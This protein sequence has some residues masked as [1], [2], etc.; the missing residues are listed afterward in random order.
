MGGCMCQLCFTNYF[1]FFL[2]DCLG[3]ESSAYW[4][5]CD[6]AEVMRCLE[7]VVCGRSVH[8]VLFIIPPR[9][10]VAGSIIFYC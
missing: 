6:Y 5:L 8:L 9:T 3:E 4:L 1:L 7:L 10:V 2:Y